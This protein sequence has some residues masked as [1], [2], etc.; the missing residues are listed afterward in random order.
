MNRANSYIFAFL[1]VTLASW[2][3]QSLCAEPYKNSTG[4]DSIIED[5]R[6]QYG[7]RTLTLAQPYMNRLIEYVSKKEEKEGLKKE[8]PRLWVVY[9][10]DTCKGLEEGA[11]ESTLRTG[12]DSFYGPER[13]RTIHM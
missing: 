12:V 2:Y 7:D 5:I 1:L 13:S 3:E 6:V 8:D 4:N 11:R 9:G 10:F